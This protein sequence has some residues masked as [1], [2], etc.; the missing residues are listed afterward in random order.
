MY[1]F[2]LKSSRGHWC[3]DKLPQ[4]PLDEVT[5]DLLLEMPL[6]AAR[7]ANKQTLCLDAHNMAQY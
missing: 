1:R 7:N 2:T 4:L 5:Q 6:F 3:F